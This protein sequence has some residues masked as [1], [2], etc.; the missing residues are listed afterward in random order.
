[1]PVDSP[2]DQA[3]YGDPDCC[4]TLHGLTLHGAAWNTQK[5]CLELQSNI[6]DRTEDYSVLLSPMSREHLYSE[7][8]DLHCPVLVAREP[9]GEPDPRASPLLHVCL[10]AE[11]AMAVCGLEG[12]V[13]L[14]CHL[15]AVDIM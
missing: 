11:S 10:E 4:L 9:R 5:Q 15:S 12:R 2:D 7:R 14:T 6:P 13:Y 8:V 3:Q 1:M